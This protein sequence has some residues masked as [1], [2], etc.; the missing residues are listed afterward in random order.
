M[1]THRETDRQ[2][3]L[4]MIK[5]LP[6]LLKKKKKEGISIDW[7]RVYLCVVDS[8]SNF[9]NDGQKKYQRKKPYS[10]QSQL[11]TSMFLARSSYMQRSSPH[12]LNY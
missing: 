7:I 11:V 2:T 1:H 3:V 12:L 4:K 9:C 5:N 6:I 8:G 10:V